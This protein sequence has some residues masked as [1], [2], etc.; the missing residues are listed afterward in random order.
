MDLHDLLR[1]LR[2]RWFVIASVAAST[3]TLAIA[4]TVLQTPLY[5]ATTQLF[6]SMSVTDNSLDAYQ[7]SLFSQQ[8]VK[9]YAKLMGSEEMAR[10][11]IANL[12]SDDDPEALMKQIHTTV[13]PDTVIL[14]VSVTDPQPRHAEDLARSAGE[15]FVKYVADLEKAPNGKAAPVKTEIADPPRLPKVPVSPNVLRNVLLA[16]AI[17]LLG[18][19]GVAALRD[20]LDVRVKTA[21]DLSEASGDA[22]LLG[23]IHYAK[24]AV[25]EPLIST[26]GRNAPRVEAF[27]VLRTNLQFVGVDSS[28]KI[29]VITSALPDEGKTT[30]AC[31]VSIALAEAGARVLLLEGDLRRPKV[32]EYFG[33]ESSVGVS[34][35]LVGRASLKEAVQT[36]GGVSILSSGRRP[37]NASEL[38]QSGAMHR[39]LQEAREVF[40]YVIID[41][42]P[43]LPVT[44]A[45]L[46]AAEAD[47]AVLVVRHGRTTTHHVR[48]ARAR[49]DAVGANLLGTIVNMTPEMKRTTG[50]YGYGYGYG[51]QYGYAPVNNPAAREADLPRFGTAV[52]ERRGAADR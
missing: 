44:D 2:E 21:E 30:T 46:L 17:G 1:I 43:L 41:A 5:Q 8:R 16:L 9:S 22:P 15:V 32:A 29:F 27:R 49:L 40:D 34:T 31:N 24:G 36:A 6:V 35:V 50:R 3:V 37:P 33:I 38:L 45:A 19:A 13:D 52:D 28:N 39:L 14:S 51:Y 20:A 42:P 10:R 48:T 4:F 23:N 12:G 25:K 26:L 47:G 18:G 11:I 7:G